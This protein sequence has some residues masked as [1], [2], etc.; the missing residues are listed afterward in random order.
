[1]LITAELPEKV[2]VDH[3]LGSIVASAE[4]KTRIRTLGFAS[5]V[6]PELSHGSISRDQSTKFLSQKDSDSAGLSI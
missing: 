1:M 6:K 2:S 3:M 5:F 4:E